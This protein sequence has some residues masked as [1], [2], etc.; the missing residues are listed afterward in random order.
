MRGIAPGTAR[1]LA[2]VSVVAA[3]IM[4]TLDTTI[5]NVALPHMQGSMN[6]SIDQVSWVLTSYMVATAISTP[7]TGYLERRL[8]RRKLFIGAVAFFVMASV[9]CGL[10]LSLEQIVLYRLIQGAAGAA[11]IPLAQAS[12]QDLFPPEQRGQAVALWG[13]GVMIG[14]IL[15]PTLGGYLT[16]AYNWRWIFFI[17]VPIGL[18]AAIGL[19]TFLPDTPV[20][21][22]TKFDLFGFTM[23]SIAL[24]SMQLMLDRGHTLDWFSSPEIVI[25]ALLAGAFAWVFLVHMFTAREP[26]MSP[27]PFRDLN[28]VVGISVMFLMGVILFAIM[29]MLPTFLQTLL[30]YPV[31]TAG[32]ALV[33]RGVG[34]MISMALAG[35]LIGKY[36]VRILIGFG[37]I[38]MGSSLWQ[39]SD[40][41]LD[42]PAMPI[43]LSGFTQGIGMGFI[44][45]PLSAA[46]FSTMPARFRTESAATFSLSRNI[47][48]SIGVSAITT[49]LAESTQANH[50]ILSQHIN[51][52]SRAL[53]T[54]LGQGGGMS[55]DVSQALPLLNMEVTRQAT[56]LAYIE[57]FQILLLLVLLTIPMVL[58]L[59]PSKNQNVQAAEVYD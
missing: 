21:R 55:G 53:D 22:R 5:A 14:P 29:A 23:L 30:G 59:T 56:M 15:G 24:A 32:N 3:T 49:N 57:D 20:E 54:Q 1:L 9:L 48:S 33:S 45:V 39:M 6:A 41:T 26:F 13:M 19:A 27:I 52:F 47:G 36:D 7:L 46:A 4:Q 51:P 50:A 17:N 28:F 43:I 34:T 42:T 16:D 2:S 25:E 11:I 44:Y 40:F 10:A 8:G 12:M 31:T 37:I 38:C 58:F 35:R 18:M